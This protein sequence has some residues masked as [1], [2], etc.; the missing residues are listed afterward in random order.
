MY[1]VGLVWS[2]SVLLHLHSFFL[3]FRFKAAVCEVK[4]NGRGLL[5]RTYEGKRKNNKK[6]Y[7]LKDFKNKNIL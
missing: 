1:V 6:Y 5:P 3:I 2:D 4:K 7:P